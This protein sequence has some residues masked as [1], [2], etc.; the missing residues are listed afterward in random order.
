MKITKYLYITPGCF[1]KG[2]ISRYSRYQITAIREIFGYDKVSV[3]S[4]L[5][6]NK[7]SF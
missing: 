2:G 7:H 6:K 4:L 5:G 3:F 1:D